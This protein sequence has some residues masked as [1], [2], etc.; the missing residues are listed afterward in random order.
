MNLF[1]SLNLADGGIVAVRP[2]KIVAVES[3]EPGIDTVR[4]EGIT[5]AYDVVA[6]QFTLNK[7]GEHCSHAGVRVA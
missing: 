3:Y 4:V 5:K 6:G 7:L 1:I 2:E